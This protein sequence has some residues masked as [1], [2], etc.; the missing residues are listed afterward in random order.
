MDLDRRLLWKANEEVHLTPREFDL[1]SFLFKNE[2]AVV[3][4]VKLLRGVW[5]PEY[6]NELEY[7]GP[8]SAYFARKSKMIPPG[9]V[10]VNGKRITKRAPA[11]ASIHM[12]PPWSRTA[13]RESANPSPSP[14]VL[15]EVMNGSNV[16]IPDHE[17]RAEFRVPYL[18]FRPARDYQPSWLQCAALRR[19]ASLQGCW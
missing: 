11:A 3:T 1:L 10:S 19:L 16:R 14:F 18:P 9:Y 5:G 17:C 6:G 2:G 8:T 4:H 15:P 12:S 7:R 13:R